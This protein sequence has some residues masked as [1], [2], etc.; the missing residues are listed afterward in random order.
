M[1]KF[2][3]AFAVF[4]MAVATT[5]GVWDFMRGHYVWGLL[6]VGCFFLNYAN[7]RSFFRN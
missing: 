1:R 5:V 6:M 4:G 7:Y 2:G 3:I